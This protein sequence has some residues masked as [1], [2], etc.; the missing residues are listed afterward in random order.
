MNLKFIWEGIS[1]KIGFS[2]L[3]VVQFV[4]AIICIFIAFQ[5]INDINKSTDNVKDSF[6]NGVYYKIDNRISQNELNAFNKDTIDKDISE[7]IKIKN[8]LNE[9]KEIRFLSAESN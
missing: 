9:D 2:I 7:L 4:V 5:T 6:S 1:K 3:T 8:K